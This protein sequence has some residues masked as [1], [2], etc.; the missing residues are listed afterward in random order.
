M[1]DRLAKVESAAGHRLL[2]YDL[3]TPTNRGDHTSATST[4][5]GRAGALHTEEKKEDGYL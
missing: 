1:A 4:G 2:K 5:A 3:S